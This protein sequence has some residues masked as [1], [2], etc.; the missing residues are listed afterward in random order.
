WASE[1][2][3][4]PAP[5]RAAADEDLERAIAFNPRDAEA[6]AVRGR[7]RLQRGQKQEALQ[8]FA[9]AVELNP[10]LEPRIARDRDARR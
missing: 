3:G 1:S 4:D 10:H 7:L 6:F 5:D 8:D 2:G 9:R